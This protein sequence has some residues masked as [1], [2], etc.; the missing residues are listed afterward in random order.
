MNNIL[1]I[2][3]LT[4][5]FPGVVAL[6]NVNIN[7]KKGEIHGICGENGAGKS[8]LIKI[9]SG[10][11]PKNTY[12]GSI[13]LNGDVI[14]FKNNKDA[15]NA[16][17]AT[18]YQE[19]SL[20]QELNIAENIFLNNEPSNK[21]GI[22][23]NNKLFK[24]TQKI[25][26]QVGI[27]SNFDEKV[28][29][30]SIGKR[31]IIEIAKALSKNVKILIFDEPTSALTDQEVETLMNI[32]KKL[33]K[34]G[35]TCIYISH[36]LSEILQICDTITTLRDGKLIGTKVSKETDI[37]K[38]TKMII[39]K[40][41][42]K[43]YPKEK[44]PIGETVLKVEDF[45][46]Y[47]KRGEKIVKNVT[48]ELKKGEILGFYGLIGAGRTE[49]FSGIFGAYPNRIDGNV[50]IQGKKVQIKSPEDAIRRGIF[51]LT[52]DRKRYGLFKDKTIKYNITI[53]TLDK[54][55]QNFTIS[56]EKETIYTSEIFDKLSI[57]ASS[58]NIY[59]KNLSG[60]NQQKVVFARA[61][62]AEPNF[63]ILDEP[64]KGIDVGAK[65]EIHNLIKK[66]ARSG[67]AVILI[68]SELSEI[69]GMSDRVI[70]M[71]EGKI[72]GDEKIETIDRGSILNNVFGGNLH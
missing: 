54:F 9:L 36:R 21:F 38:L 37:K 50:Y 66:I 57:K 39:G 51:L 35:I 61:L 13:L 30:L 31:Q 14:A 3:N 24:E 49:L 52:E 56:E 44:I 45:C 12:K 1:E 4:K 2:K 65:M 16:G 7:I 41:I 67:V 27:D 71:H 58:L 10:I 55:I 64:T 72:T 22:I 5:V 33:K 46:V 8:T 70:T 43:I 20:V 62:M 29:N 32:L 11:Y 47:D 40:E 53:S 26:E 23:D 28:A 15:K 17:I 69:I 6:D 63:F 19:L 34:K 60:G 68:A 42:E 18:I 59:V 48:F 25:L